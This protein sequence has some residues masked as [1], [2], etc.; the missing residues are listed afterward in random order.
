MN[1]ELVKIVILKCNGEI[2]AE[3]YSQNQ[4]ASLKTQQQTTLDKLVT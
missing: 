3:I 4:K 2:R 1:F